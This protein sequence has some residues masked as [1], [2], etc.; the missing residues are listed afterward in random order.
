MKYAFVALIPL[1]APVFAQ[2]ATLSADDLSRLKGADVVIVGEV[3][4]NPTHHQVQAQ[5]VQALVPN[6]LVVEM[7]GQDEAD[8]LAADPAGYADAW[9]ESGW[10][11]YQM[12]LP[13]FRAHAGPIVGAGVDRDAA[14][15][16]Y[17]D[18]VEAHFQGDAM[19]YGL[20]EALPEAQQ[21][22]RIELQFQAHC[23][24]MPR[25][26]MGGMIEVQRLRD[27]TLAAGVVRA[28][29]DT[30][31]PVVVITGNG[32]ARRDW[33]VPSYLARVAPDV[34][35]AVVGQGEDDVA[36]EGGFDII[37]DALAPER[38]DPCAQ[39]K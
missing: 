9:A 18:G 13:V 21:A 34:T 17:S 38:D 35:V 22:Q 25:E 23:E 15:A 3:H 19:A 24:A 12:Y 39:F 29:G 33:G 16:T 1:A 7:L 20:T 10:P 27:A 8:K 14:R 26:M 11:D 4:D 2:D 28:L 32:H 6:A 37:L 30:G 5:I 31:G 36:P